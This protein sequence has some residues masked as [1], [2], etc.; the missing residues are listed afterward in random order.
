MT[1]D[2]RD[3]T[4]GEEQIDDEGRNPTQ[5]RMDEEGVEPAPVDASWTG[6]DESE[7][8]SVR[9]GQPERSDPSGQP[10]GSDPSGPPEGGMAEPATSQA[11]STQTSGQPQGTVPSGSPESVA[12]GPQ[13]NE[14]IF[15]PDVPLVAEVNREVG[16]GRSR[17]GVIAAVAGGFAVLGAALL[18]RR[19]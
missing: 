14:P 4:S 7:R 3:E 12:A 16:A 18:R 9:S 17:K 11:T 19:R 5:Q 6:D 10:E 8:D 2:E 1:D 13:A 15:E